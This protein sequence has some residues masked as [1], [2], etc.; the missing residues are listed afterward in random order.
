[1]IRWLG[2]YY[3]LVVRRIG[4]LM[5]G[6]SYAYSVYHMS[7]LMLVWGVWVVLPPDTFNDVPGYEQM[8]RLASGFVWGTVAIILGACK[9]HFIMAHMR[10][11][12][13]VFCLIAGFYW[14]LVG[15]SFLFADSVNTGGPVYL[16]LAV[17][18][19]WLY[20]KLTRA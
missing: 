12:L 8:A 16:M 11:H 7:L 9:M 20:K 13:S 1:M 6:D 10:T 18:E 17:Y 3:D 15:V 14:S 5:S 2:N 4:E 19:F